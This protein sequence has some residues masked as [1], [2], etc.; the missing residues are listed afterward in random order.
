[1]IKYALDGISPKEFLQ[2]NNLLIDSSSDV[3]GIVRE[4][5]AENKSAFEEYKK[6][7]SKSLNFLIGQV[8][9]KLKGKADARLV[10]KSIEGLK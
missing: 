5:V 8:M 9:R 4:V 7:N 6:G 1:M 3:E 10:Q 2:K